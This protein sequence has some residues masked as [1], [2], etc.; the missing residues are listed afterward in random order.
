MLKM[1]LRQFVLGINAHHYK[2]LEQAVSGLTTEQ[3]NYQ[4]KPE[5]NCIGWLIWHT[6]RSQDRM[7]ADLFG[8]DQLW[9]SGN[10]YLK[11]NRLPDQNDTGYGHTPAQ[12][13]NFKAPDAETLIDYALAVHERTALYINARLTEDDL[14]REVIS[15]TLKMT[16]AVEQR[17]LSTINDFQLIGQAGYVRGMLTG[18]GWYG[19]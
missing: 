2:E 1:D 14:E 16:T 8:G 9:L 4:P 13:T 3:L 17:I 7:N 19:R 15:P 5:S 11:F 10:W 6:T 18:I 12:V